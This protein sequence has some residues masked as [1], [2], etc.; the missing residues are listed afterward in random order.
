MVCFF[1]LDHHIWF[2][3]YQIVDSEPLSLLEIGP[4]FTLEPAAILNGCCKGSVIWK[5]ELAKTPTEQ[6]R[7]R[8]TRRLEKVQMNEAIKIKSEMHKAMN[9]PPEQNPLDLVFKEY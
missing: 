2:R 6:R 1:Y 3:H 4:R 9:P 5:S 7:D 8:K